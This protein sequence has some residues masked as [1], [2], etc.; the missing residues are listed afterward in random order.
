MTLGQR[1]KMLRKSH[2]F[3]TRSGWLYD[4]KNEL[5][6]NHS[7]VWAYFA[8]RS[9]TTNGVGVYPI[10]F[11]YKS[12]RTPAEWI[13]WLHD[14]GEMIVRNNAIPAITRKHGGVHRLEKFLGMTAG[15]SD[16]LGLSNRSATRS[17]RNK[18]KRQRCKNG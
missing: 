3:V 6:N 10:N 1:L 8:V 15:R 7:S 9:E 18:A 11:N 4:H 2:K 14:T 13:D 17:K 5:N 16:A 12:G